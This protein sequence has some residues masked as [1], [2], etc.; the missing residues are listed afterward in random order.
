[1]RRK[2]NLFFTTSLLLSSSMSLLAFTIDTNNISINNF[3]NNNVDTKTATKYAN[4][5]SIVGKSLLIA[6][7]KG[8]N[9]NNLLN[10]MYNQTPSIQIDNLTGKNTGNDFI[11]DW[12]SNLDGNSINTIQ[13]L[14][15]RNGINQ[16]KVDA[17]TNNIN[18]YNSYRDILPMLKNYLNNS[19]LSNDDTVNMID[20]MLKNIKI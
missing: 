6:K 18:S 9:T 10:D 14:F 4:E 8:F 19:I 20:G 3:A 17:I 13:A 7:N 1:M 11:N 12:T 15:Q 5:T 2:L 16:S